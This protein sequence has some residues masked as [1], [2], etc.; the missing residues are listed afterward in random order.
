MLLTECSASLTKRGTYIGSSVQHMWMTKAKEEASCVTHVRDLQCCCEV[1]WVVPVRMR[2][3]VPIIAWF[4]LR[5]VSML[6][7]SAY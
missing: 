7:T 3:A 5:F 4:A 1:A 2:Y 6:F